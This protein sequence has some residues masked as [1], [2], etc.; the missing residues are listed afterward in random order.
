[1]A[2][3]RQ[4]TERDLQII[5]RYSAQHGQVVAVAETVADVD[6]GIGAPLLRVPLLARL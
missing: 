4:L 3:V 2:A 6:G 5:N 1:M